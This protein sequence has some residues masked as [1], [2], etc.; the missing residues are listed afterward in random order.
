MPS[1]NPS[2]RERLLDAMTV[3]AARYGYR[4]ASIAR[5]LAQAGMSRATF[6][7][8]FE[9]KEACFL[10]VYR[11]MAKRVAT[12][13]RPIDSRRAPAERPREVLRRLL[14]AADREP[15]SARIVLLESLAAGPSVRAEHERRLEEMEAAMDAYLDG[16]S[17]GG[18]QIEIPARAL[19]GGLAS[20]V[21][22]RVFRGEAGRLTALFDDLDAWL[23]SYSM[24]SGS[25][26]RRDRR[27]W[28]R[29]GRHLAEPIAPEPGP[30]EE[31]L[32]RGRA[33]LAPAVVASEQR[34]R[35]LAAVARL[36]REKGYA[37]TTVADIVATAGVAREVFYEQFRSKEDAFLAAQAYAL[38]TSVSHAAGRFFNA[39]AWP[40]RVWSGVVEL[41]RFFSSVPDLAALDVVESYTAGSAAIRRSFEGRMAF[42]LFLEEGYRQRAGMDPLPRICS[43]AIAGAILELLRRQAV[44]GR[45]AEAQQLIPQAVYVALAPFIGPAEALQ[46]V[47]ARAAT[48]QPGRPGE[49]SR[50]PRPGG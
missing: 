6:Y 40:D 24:P 8:H 18:R 15:A 23:H 21:A 17:V 33:A 34:Q 43:E 38:E 25:R 19:L 47:E 3:T 50:E 49:R 13:L 31:R 37:T 28:A 48:A 45:V 41:L 30:L 4:E 29:L 39:E 36:A 32:P 14:E 1:P 7:Q 10:A 5:V 11:E 35:L 9:D 44:E 27:D 2:Q 20:V 16:A 26:G 46:L 12:D 22:I 42:T